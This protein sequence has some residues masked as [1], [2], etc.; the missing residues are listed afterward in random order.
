MSAAYDP[1][2]TRERLIARRALA[3][4]NL[5]SLRKQVANLYVPVT[6]LLAE[7]IA[8]ARLLLDSLDRELAHLPD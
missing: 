8:D 7:A 4:A 3:Q 5:E 1:A 6:P 2:A